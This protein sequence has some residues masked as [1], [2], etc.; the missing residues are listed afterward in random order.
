MTRTTATAAFLLGMATAGATMTATATSPVT[1]APAEVQER[2][3]DIYRTIIGFETVAGK[4]QVPV[5]A[6]YLAEKFRA[7]GF[8]SEDIHILPLGETASLVVRYAGDGTGGKPI[9][10]LAHMDV[11]VAKREDWTRDPF[12]LVEQNGYF[13]GRGTSDIKGDIALIAATFLRL[14]GEGFLPNRDLIIAFSGDEETDMATT[15]SLVGEHRALLRDPEFALNADGGVGVLDEATGEA[16]V[17]YVQGAE[18]V[19]ATYELTVRNPGGHS[20]EPRLDNAIYKLADALKAA[21]AYRFPVMWNDWTIG[22]FR[23]AA[24]VTRGSLGDAMKRFAADPSDEAAANVLY[25]NPSYVGLT[26]TTCIPTRLTAGHADNA[27]PQS[28][29]ATMNCRI[30]P[31]VGFESVRAALASVVGEGVEVRLTDEGV[32]SDASPMRKDVMAAVAT[33]VHASYPRAPIVP[34][35]AA[36]ATDGSVFRGAGIPTYG[37][38]GIFL[39]DSESFSHGL[40]ER[41]PVKGFMHGLTHWYVLIKELAGDEGSL[42]SS[43]VATDDVHDVSH[44][45]KSEDSRHARRSSSSIVFGQS[46]LSRRANE[47]S[48]SRRPSVWHRGQ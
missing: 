2:A 3:R 7:A 47:R 34:Q 19:Y 20:S 16:A 6:R 38:S 26:R 1:P 45:I 17:Y 44:V 46:S 22:S 35:M 28:A 43:Q 25:E 31:G 5:M 13:F 27:L 36:Y 33:A 18:K 24:D 10:L 40:N 30:F 23:A 29:T 15:R 21:Q 48:E 14:K 12:T 37:V 4:G 9:V 32:P 8:P 41:V 11:V 39:K 42:H